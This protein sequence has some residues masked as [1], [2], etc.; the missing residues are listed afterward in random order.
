MNYAKINQDGTIAE[1]PYRSPD[2]LRPGQELPADVV[3]V[4]MQ[5]NR[6]S[7]RWDQKTSVTGAEKSGDKY[8][9]VYGP[10]VKKYTDAESKLKAITTN[11]KI[12][13]GSNERAFAYK[14]KEL[15]A[16]Y[17][18]GERRSWDQQRSEAVAYTAD[19]TVSTPLLSVI[20]EARGITVTELAERVLANAAEYDVAY[21]TLLGKYQKNKD[22]LAGIDLEDETT[23]NAIDELVRL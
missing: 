5:V 1:F 3:E 9:A 18:E 22:I 13:Q 12:K 4:D 6:P 19:N 16:A 17:T 21:G 10:V 23:W 8:V 20:A 7:L 15:V 14:S 2:L 11:K